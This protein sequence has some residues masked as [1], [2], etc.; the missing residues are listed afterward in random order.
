MI[1]LTVAVIGGLGVTKKKQ[2]V[3][4]SPLLKHYKPRH[5]EVYTYDE[6]KIFDPRFLQTFRALS[7]QT[8]F[9]RNETLSRRNF[10]L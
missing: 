4:L 7:L 9:Q 2:S 1:I 3:K 6:R 5:P 8:E 10:K